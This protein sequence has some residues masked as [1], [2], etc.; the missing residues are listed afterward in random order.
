VR[1]GA[2]LALRIDGR[3]EA[4]A[5]V[6]ELHQ[7]VPGPDAA[8]KLHVVAVAA[9]EKADAAADL[10]DL[11]L[12]SVV[13]GRFDFALPGDA[14]AAAPDEA[15]APAQPI[16]WKEAVRLEREGNLSDAEQLV[17]HAC[18]RVRGLLEVARLYRDRALR[19]AR[20]GDTRG[21][22]L[23]S[24]QMERWAER[25]AATAVNQEQREALL[26][27]RTLTLMHD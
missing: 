23:A 9:P 7:L 13:F 11:L 2:R 18:D 25:H 8:R 21:A 10:V 16:W 5:P 12:R 3:R 14:P 6:Q 20:H 15:A 19:L 27:E 26:Y 22:A 1:R 4:A 17:L 24:E